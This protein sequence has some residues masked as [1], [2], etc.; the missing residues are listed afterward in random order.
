IAAILSAFDENS[1]DY[2]T[3][4][5]REAV[6]VVGIVRKIVRKNTKSGE[7]MAF[8]T[9]EDYLGEIEVIVF[10]AVYLKISHL[11]TIDAAI[12]VFGTL[13]SR[14]DAA[15]KLIAQKIT[16]LSPNGSTQPNRQS[17][18][19]NAK[20]SGAVSSAQSNTQK[21]TPTV[22]DSAHTCKQIFIRLDSFSCKAYTRVLSLV[23]IFGYNGNAEVILYSKES[24]KY[25][26]LTSQKLNT[27]PKVLETLYEICGKDNIILR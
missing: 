14:E 15:V 11:L 9:L 17:L 18:Q 20:P 2:G 5:D 3:M 8:I 27:L 22:K 23:S 7:T 13:S 19:Q 21:P 25:Q 26:K 6:S 24:A 16:P 1:E 12:S 10:S 4:K